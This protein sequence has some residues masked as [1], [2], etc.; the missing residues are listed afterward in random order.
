MKIKL[1]QFLKVLL[2][3]LNTLFITELNAQVVSLKSEIILVS[4]DTVKGNMI[5]LRNIF[6]KK[7]INETS[8]NEKLSLI[9]QDNKKIKY[10]WNEISILKFVD[11]EAKERTFIQKEGYPRL[12]EVMYKNKVSWFN[13]Y[14]QG[15]NYSQNVSYEL[16]NETGKRYTIGIF[17]SRKNKLT[18]FCDGHEQIISFINDNPMTDENILH[19]LK[20][21]EKE[22]E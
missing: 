16:F 8:F 11:L 19:V 21:Y 22:L 1:K 3:V 7:L 6:F 13:H 20:M 2:I 17:N 14:Y 12:L 5:A 18:L 10:R 15:Y 9:N 4:G